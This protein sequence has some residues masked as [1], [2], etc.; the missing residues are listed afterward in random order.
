MSHFLLDSI[1][2]INNTEL[3]GTVNIEV[4]LTEETERALLLRSYISIGSFVRRISRQCR[5]I[6]G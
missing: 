6:N 5:Y 2:G 4:T 3:R 1:G